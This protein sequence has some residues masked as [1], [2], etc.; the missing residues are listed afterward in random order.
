MGGS[1][2]SGQDGLEGPAALSPVSSAPAACSPYPAGKKASCPVGFL[3]LVFFF[4][5]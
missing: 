5:S 4:F 2:C 1:K 3:F